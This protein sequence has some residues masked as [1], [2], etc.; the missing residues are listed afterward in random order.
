VPQDEND[1]VGE[2][3]GNIR[4]SI[5][6]VCISMRSE[7]NATNPAQLEELRWP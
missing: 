7:S 2:F 1:N 5:W 4:K 6:S 3:Q